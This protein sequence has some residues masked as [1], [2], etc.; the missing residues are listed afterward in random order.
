MKKYIGFSIIA[1]SMG[2][3]SCN[4]FLDKLPDNRAELTSEANIQLLLTSAYPS[5]DFIAVTEYASDNVDDYGKNNPYTDRF[6]DQLYHWEDV[7]ETN[8][9]S[10]ENVWQASYNAI[11]SANQALESIKEIE[12]ETE[13]LRQAKGEALLCRAYNHF[14]LVNIFSQHYKASDKTSLGVPYADFPETTLKPEYERIPVQEVYKRI[15]EDLEEGLKLVGESYYT[16]PKYHFN[17][18]AAYAFATR[19]YLYYEKYDKAIECANVVLGTN[20]TVMLRDWSYQ[21][22]MTQDFS[23]I[24]QHYI[25]ASLNC[26]LLLNTAYSSIGLAFGPY[27]VWKRYSHGSY[28]GSNED[29]YAT[30]IWGGPSLIFNPIKRYSATNLNAYIFWRL[31]YLFEYKDHVAGTGYR[32]T[33]YPAFTADEVLLNRA[34]AYALTKQLDLAA[35]DLTA[36][37]QNF[38]NTNMVLTP[39]NIQDFYNSI[40]YSYEVVNTNGTASEDGRVSTQKKHLHPSF[41]IEKEGSE[42]ECVLQCV[43]GFRRL[44]TLHSGMRWFDIKRWGIEIPRRVMNAD[45]EPSEITDWLRVDDARRAIQIPQ[46]VISAGLAPNPRVYSTDN[47]MVQEIEDK[48]LLKD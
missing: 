33:V 6:L 15:E 18:K 34:E 2:L 9:E 26:N 17:K 38:V 40:G 35:K 42:Q 5:S 29:G 1:F 23:A 4:D 39:Q 8:N 47:N 14:I 12:V 24:T 41:A 30:N 25:D 28:I 16:V 37:M 3:A 20:P 36:W 10:P 13:T 46:K 45:G 21:A 32:R 43:L 48:Y 11:A 31:P 19:F 7:T 27:Y 44:E 22:S